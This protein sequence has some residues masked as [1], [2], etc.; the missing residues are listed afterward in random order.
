M[1]QQEIFDTVVRA[2]GKQGKPALDERGKCLY[3]APDGSKCAAGHLIPD[4]VYKRSMEFQTIRKVIADTPEL[5]HLA[6][7]S[8]ILMDLQSAHD[9]GFNRGGITDADEFVRRVRVLAD[10]NHLNPAVIDE[11]FPLATAA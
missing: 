4:D 3:R 10:K 5:K 6:P 1:T 11:A 8:N 2:L 7:N 9:S